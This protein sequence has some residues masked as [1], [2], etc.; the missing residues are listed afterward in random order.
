MKTPRRGTAPKPMPPLV[1][2]GRRP[3]SADAPGAKGD[4]K[5]RVL[6]ATGG[7]AQ[8]IEAAAFKALPRQQQIERAIKAHVDWVRRQNDPEALERLS[9]VEFWRHCL[10]SV[11]RNAQLIDTGSDARIVLRTATARELHTA[12]TALR[13][14]APQSTAVVTQPKI[15]DKDPWWTFIKDLRLLGSA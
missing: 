7:V 1:I 8:D 14:L 5:I 15:P 3:K 13:H 4:P 2:R 6:N 10:D 9:E 12:W 11:L